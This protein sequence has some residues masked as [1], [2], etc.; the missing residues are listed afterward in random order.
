VIVEVVFGP[1]PQAK[2]QHLIEL[3]ERWL[4]SFRH[5]LV[6]FLRPLHLDLGPSSPWGRFRRNRAAVAGF[7]REELALRRDRPGAGLLGH[8]IQC[9]HEGKN[10]SD[11][12]LVSEAITF[13]LF[14]HDTTAAAMGWVLYHLG[15]NQTSRQRVIDEWNAN[16]AADVAADPERSAFTRAA[17]EESMRLCP[18]VVHLT[19][20]AL[21]S[22][23]VGPHTIA[24]D[25][26]VLPCAYLA[27]HNPAV[28][29]DPYAFRPERFLDGRDYRNAYFPFGFGSRICAGM[30]FALRQMV[31]MTG[32]FASQLS[33]RLAEPQH[34]RPARKMV[35]IVPSGGPLLQIA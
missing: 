29:D 16:A 19:R 33:Y 26:R 23:K 31:T 3:I 4:I 7:I 6:L 9:V 24:K 5:P 21:R 13:L 14:G 11:D 10:L 34:I 27:H 28:F 2:H 25:E 1:L 15:R 30:P 20:H 17:V 22:T 12:E 32:L 18:V 8:A 35:L